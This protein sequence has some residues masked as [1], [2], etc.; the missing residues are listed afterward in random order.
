MKV[1]ITG[2][3][4]FDGETINPAL[5]AVKLLPNSIAGAEI[6]IAELPVVFRQEAQVLIELVEEHN[7]DIVICVG[8]AGG[9]PAISVERVAINLQDARIP[10]NE[11]NTPVDEPIK[12]D[13][14]EAYFSSLP[15]RA[16]V[17]ALREQGIPAALS[18]SAGTYVCNDVM[19]HLLYWIDKHGW[20]IQGGFIHVPYCPAQAANIPSS[21][22]SMSITVIAG[23]LEVAI[24]AAVKDR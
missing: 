14:K 3:S 9:R 5:E 13:G 18:Y 22:P 4:P 7:P 8:Q 6:I 21:P 2:F 1:L 12:A 15:T 16:M 17:Q 23:A 19:Y 20:D 24:G 11:G 10:D